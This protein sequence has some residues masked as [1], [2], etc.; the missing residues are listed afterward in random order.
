IKT[1]KKQTQG[2][3]H[4]KS[5]G[6]GRIERQVL[7]LGNVSVSLRLPYVVERSKKLNFKCRKTRGQGF[8][9]FLR[10]LSMEE[11]ITPLV[12]SVV[13]FNGSV[14]GSFAIARQI[15]Q[16]WGISISIQRIERL[17]YHF[18]KQGL[19]IRNFQLFQLKQGTLETTPVLKAHRV[20]ISVDGGRTRIRKNKTGQRRQHSHRHGYQGEWTEPKLLT[21][22]VVDQYGKRINT[23]EIPVTN[24]GTYGKLQP[25][26]SLLE[27]H[28]VR[29]GINL[30]SKVLLIAD[31]AE[32]IWKH[33]PP[34][35][36]RLGCPPESTHQLL[37]FYHATEYLQSFADTAFTQPK[38]RIAWFKT[39]RSTLK[40]GQAQELIQ[41]MQVLSQNAS[42]EQRSTM[43][44]QIR[45]LQKFSE[46][47]RLSYHQLAA[48]KM[49]IGS[50]AIESLIRQ[51][52][53]LRLKGNG[54]FW[55][56]E[57]AEAILH[58]R[59]QWAAGSWLTFC[60]SILIARLYPA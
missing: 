12:W 58:A 60:D 48:M 32:W 56:L 44:S 35:L 29:L 8:C 1:A 7:C 57:N 55:L 4:P 33:I 53:N 10:W 50:G 9:P 2:W 25:F 46:Q 30:A 51:V 37:D 16:D 54:K 43:N 14:S 15:V 24:D 45:Y 5:Q 23:T 20:V 27:M 21:I 36:Q 34:L 47:G 59:C 26:L 42:H 22:Y 11:G 3:R 31:G 19:S 28:L 17:T 18:N 40:R 52:V 13:A 41:Q 39:A 38:E 49:P 6:N